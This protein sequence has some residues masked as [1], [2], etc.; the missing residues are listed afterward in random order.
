[1]E[2]PKEVLDCTKLLNDWDSD[3]CSQEVVK[4]IKRIQ[5]HLT[6]HDILDTD[7]IPEKHSHSHNN[8]NKRKHKN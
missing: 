6:G 1:M 4:L 5:K 2:T 8:S 7:A 3:K